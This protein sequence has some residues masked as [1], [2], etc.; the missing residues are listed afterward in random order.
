M[1]QE[2]SKQNEKNWFFFLSLA[3]LLGV[4]LRLS[5]PGDIE[6]KEDERFMF[7]AGQKIGV[8][9][10]WPLLGMHSGAGIPNPGMSV[11]IFVLLSKISHVSTPPQ[12]ARA[13]QL[14]NILAL[15]ALAFFSLRV[16]PQTERRPWFWATAFTAVSPLAVV[17]QRKIWAQST[18][19][20]F[21]M[22]LWI[23]WHYRQK[24]IGAF[25]WGL[26]G[27]CLG[28]IHLSGF[29]F[30]AGVFL[31]T[32]FH[33]RRTKWGFWLLG[34]LFGAIP[35]IP[36]LQ[37][38]VTQQ[39]HGFNWLIFLTVFYP[40][41]W[42]Y[43]VSDALGLGLANS[44]KT[45]HYLDFL[46]YPLMG[47]TGTYLVAIAHVVIIVNV[48]LILISIKKNRSFSLIFQDNSET[49]LATNAVLLGSGVVMSLMV[50]NICR[51]Y[52][53]VTFPFEWIWL[54]RMGLCDSRLGQRY[55]FII[56]IAQFVISVSFLFYIHVN[57]GDSL[58]DYGIAY[59]FQTK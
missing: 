33:D 12:L 54:S 4:L 32:I 20:L 25:F 30:A 3:L 24:R 40:K 50:V 15:F 48:V 19:P 43:W 38:M 18:L 2:I 1:S 7:E 56:W 57:H 55:L 45:V 52:L 6:Y 47:G 53:I 21:C 10:T 11:W 46:R 8:S 58:G 49:G 41:Y 42:I 36:W 13:V 29:I 16:L 27:I 9:E 17:F 35:L 34:S 59:Q 31:W 23:A 5:F 39:G 14:L 37:A 51:Q 22:L 28:Q 26:I 44:L